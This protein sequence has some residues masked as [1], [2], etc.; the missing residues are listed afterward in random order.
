MKPQLS[1]A[2]WIDQTCQGSLELAAINHSP[3]TSVYIK[4][5]TCP[6]QQANIEVSKEPKIGSSTQRW[7]TTHLT[8]T[9]RMSFKCSGVTKSKRKTYPV[10]RKTAAP[11]GVRAGDA[12]T[13]H[14]V[15]IKARAADGRKVPMTVENEHSEPV[16]IRIPTNLRAVLTMLCHILLNPSKV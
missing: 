13:S 8:Y 5:R 9:F 11:P 6:T 1:S 12:R 16:A 4:A 14:Q 2:I 15:K 7:H 3:A 10:L